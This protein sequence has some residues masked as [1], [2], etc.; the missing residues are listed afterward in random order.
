MYV[1]K[2]YSENKMAVTKNIY[3]ETIIT[4]DVKTGEVDEVQHTNIVKLPTEPP[5][6]KLYL[7]D[8]QKVYNLPNNTILYELLK[9]MNYEGEVVLNSSEKKKICLTLNIKNQTIDNYIGKL[10]KAGVFKSIDTGTFIPNP[11]LFGRGDWLTILSRRKTFATLKN[12]TDK[13][14]IQ[15]NITYNEAGEKEIKTTFTGM[16]EENE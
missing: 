15:M 8:L 9:R 7:E 14:T 3:Q 16:G 11:N 1:R 5:Y 12:H 10:K 4:R 2:L 6:I 13:D